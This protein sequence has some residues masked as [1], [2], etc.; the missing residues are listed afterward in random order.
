MSDLL[1][2]KIEEQN[3]LFNTMQEIQSRSEDDNRDW[4]AEE[5]TNW[6][7]ANA[8][9]DVV[10]GDIERIQ[11]LAARDS[12]DRSQTIR[13]GV[14]DD[15]P[16]ETPEARNAA[17]LV[18][19]EDA[20]RS[21]IRHGH[22]RLS[23]EQRNLMEMR[24][25]T[26]PQATTPGNVGGYLIPPGYRETMT[27]AL[28]A[29]GGLYNH[30]NVIH[31]STGNPLQWPSNDDTSNKGAILAENSVV[32]VNQVLFGTKSIGAYTYTSNRVMVSLQLLQDS[33]FDLD[34]FLPRKLGE[35]LG[36]I[37]ADHFITGD[38][39]T[40][41]EGIL[42][43]ASTGVTA[44]SGTGGS[45]LTYDNLIDLE[46]SI[47][48]AYRAIGNTRFLFNDKTLAV[49]RK[50]KDT[51]GRPLWLPVPVPG[52]VSTV[53]GVPYTIDQSMPDVGAGAKSVAYGDFNAGYIVRQVLDIH[54]MRLA[55]RWA[56]FLQVGFFA[57]LRL[58][59]KVDDARAYK[60]LVNV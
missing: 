54:F 45:Q 28:K 18:R 14:S 4:T 60:V 59:A 8:D 53:N 10:C 46:H 58:D 40:Q 48:P 36:R 55:E 13:A 7:A 15:G 35:R 31:T 12:V 17:E 29:Y 41:P 32:P 49:I 44:A 20:F 24:A 34:T 27:E 42:T 50:I 57:F 3:R 21:Y 23:D 19:Y 16:A 5:R 22:G 56:D 30:A 6:D 11:S 9:L 39:S 2:R 33:A 26:D 37:T 1:K 38:G 51:Q 43:N 47:D 25:S 52:M